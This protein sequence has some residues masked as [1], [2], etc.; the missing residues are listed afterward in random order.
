MKTLAVFSRGFVLLLLP[1]VL[2]YVVL[3]VFELR[4]TLPDIVHGSVPV[5]LGRSPFLICK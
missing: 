2:K 1:P 5:L 4:D 3:V